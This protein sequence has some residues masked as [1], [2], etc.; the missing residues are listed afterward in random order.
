M[1]RP[2]PLIRTKPQLAVSFLPGKSNL[3]IQGFPTISKHPDV[4]LAAALSPSCSCCRAFSKVSPLPL[5]LQLF[6]ERLVRS[7]ACSPWWTEPPWRVPSRSP[8]DRNLL[9]IH[10]FSSQLPCWRQKPF[11]P[12]GK[13]S[14]RPHFQS[15]WFWVCLLFQKNLNFQS[16]HSGTSYAVAGSLLHEFLE[17][18][19]STE[20]CPARTRTFEVSN[21]MQFLVLNS[22][23]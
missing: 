4:S 6:L 20:V 2:S 22:L 5:L 18:D 11:I 13:S 14:Y 9:S 12:D 15:S 19:G 23:F 1:G 17:E 10:L 16:L 21:K 8:E 3:Q 7:L